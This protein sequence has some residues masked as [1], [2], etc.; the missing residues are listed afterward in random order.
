MD[1][2]YIG[3]LTKK[4]TYKYPLIVQIFHKTENQNNWSSNIYIL[5]II[6]AV[7]RLLKLDKSIDSWFL[8]YFIFRNY[9]YIITLVLVLIISM[10]YFKINKN[11]L[12]KTIIV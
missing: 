8:L 6:R 10:F 5:S 3:A 1:N 4:F 7:I 12:V 9:I 11:K 2:T